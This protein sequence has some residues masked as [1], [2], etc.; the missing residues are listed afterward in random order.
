MTTLHQEFVRIAKRQGSRLMII[1]RTTEKRIT[2]S[3]ALI[4]GLILRQK[5]SAYR[6]GF[7]GIMIP[8]SAGSMLSILGVLLSGKVPVMINYSTGAAENAEYAQK[9]CGFKTI[10]TSRALLEKIRCPL[11]PG[12]VFIE[13]IMAGVS[14]LDKLQAALLS[15]LPVGLLQKKVHQG[16]PDDNLVILFTSGSEKDPKAVQLTHRNIGSNV[17]ACSKALGVHREDIMMANLPLFHVFGHNVNFW[18]PVLN[19]ITAVSYA[20]PL[21]YKKVASICRE[22]KATLMV[23]TPS[24][25]FG[26]LRQSE[27]G[28]FSTIRVAVA[29]ADK[30]PDALRE[31]FRQKHNLELYEG[32]GT[33]ETSPVVSVNLPGRNKPGSIGPVLEGVQVKIA[34]INT[35][36]NLP[37]GQEG[38]ILV[39]GELVMKGYFDDF[40]ETSLRIKDGWYETG[41]MG[42]LDHD[43]YLW[44]RGRLK[45]FVKIGGEMVSMVRVESMLE[46]LL[47]PDCD[48]CVVEVP[49]SLKGARIVA[50]VTTKVDE[51]QILGKLS[52]KLP[53]IAMPRQFLVIPELPKMGSGKIDFRGVTELVRAHLQN[54]I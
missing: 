48:C 7:I 17:Y 28:D 13:D 51:K 14:G 24:F 49:D 29:G 5:F 38:K 44:H 37:P 23:A 36:E 52:G 6:D 31:G 4:A 43:G 34:D 12:M 10:I 21:E 33:T 9:K 45:R 20:N 1:D 8:T 15:K 40:E 39:K 25:F 26:Y 22:E 32:Y 47:P 42:V 35:G 2:Y 11:V 53:A 30:T 19:G 50:A 27:P 54:E 3:K 18:L 41:D 46:G 16:E